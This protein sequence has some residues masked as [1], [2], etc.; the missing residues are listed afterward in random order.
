ML[1][2]GIVPCVYENTILKVT[3]LTGHFNPSE[4]ANFCI[5]LKQ[6]LY[7]CRIQYNYIMQY[8]RGNMQII[9]I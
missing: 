2:K 8:N 3:R 4:L 6:I 1:Q 5:Y 9:Y 7:A